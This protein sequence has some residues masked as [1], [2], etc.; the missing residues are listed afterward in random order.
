[1]KYPIGVWKKLRCNI[2]NYKRKEKNMAE[3]FLAFDEWKTKYH[4]A[5]YLNSQE[6]DEELFEEW[7]EYKR[8]AK[9]ISENEQA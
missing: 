8:A 3:K 1:M 2:K 7:L 9:A 5:W 4:P 6:K